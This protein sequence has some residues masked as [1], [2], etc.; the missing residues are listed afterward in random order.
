MQ[1]GRTENANAKNNNRE[2]KKC[3]GYKLSFQGI[4]CKKFCQEKAKKMP[5]NIC[6]KCNIQGKRPFQKKMQKN[7]KIMPPHSKK[8]QN[9]LKFKKNANINNAFAYL[10]P[11]PAFDD[12]WAE[13][14]YV[15][16]PY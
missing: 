7:A 13:S 2:R 6:K 5:K 9:G 3:N 10:A 15:S 1:I 12:L 16:G 4:K 8:V 11:S 14:L